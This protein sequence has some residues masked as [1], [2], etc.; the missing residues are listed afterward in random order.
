VYAI[1]GE[2][3]SDAN[4]LKVLVR[5]LAGNESLK[6]T[7]KGFGGSSKMLRKGAR[8]LR[9]LRRLKHTRFIIC[10]DAD[11]P[12]PRP[13][14]R[15]VRE[16][17]V[18]P[19]GVTEQYCIVIPVQELEAW[20]LADIESATRVFRSWVPK[21]I[22][23]PEGIPKPKEHLERL[24]KGSKGRPLYSHATHNE[25]MAKYLDLDV[26]KGKCPSFRTLADF[27]TG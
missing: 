10:H 26:V 22:D 13:K 23:N 5:K 4:T 12:D 9:N 15:L 8:E 19:S 18:K 27:V 25:Q 17:I 3:I 6:V 1:L 16:Q 24:S 7:P 14:G 11:G 20:I 2:D 21:P